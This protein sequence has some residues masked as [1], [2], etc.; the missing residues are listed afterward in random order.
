MKEIYRN[1]ITMSTIVALLV[2]QAIFMTSDAAA[3]AAM[4]AE[5][6]VTSERQS[7][8]SFEAALSR[9]EATCSNLDKKASITPLELDSSRKAAGDLKRQVPQ[10]QQAI[11]SIIDKLKAAKAWDDFDSTALAKAKALRSVLT[12]NGGAKR[13]LEDAASQ[14]GGLSGEVDGLLQPLG[15][16]LRAD[17]GGPFSG[18]EAQNLRS[19]T[20]R[21]SFNPGAPML[22]RSARCLVRI[23]ISTVQLTVGSKADVQE[24]ID[25]CKRLKEAC[26]SATG[27]DGTLSA[28]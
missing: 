10:I 8:V 3:T 18:R 4:L 15:A 27:C 17:A 13:I 14:L 28:D 26:G 23:A 6:N 12:Q 2:A 24:L 9:L 11:R 16:K 1:T 5:V 25:V 7:L 22:I 20:V 19:R 21:A